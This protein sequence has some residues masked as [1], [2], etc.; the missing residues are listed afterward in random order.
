MDYSRSA[1]QMT[2]KYIPAY[3]HLKQ[4]HSVFARFLTKCGNTVK[5]FSINTAL[6]MKCLQKYAYYCVGF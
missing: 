3:R 1:A 4:F 6:I 2:N 5:I